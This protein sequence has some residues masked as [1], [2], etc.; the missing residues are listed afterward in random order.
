MNTWRLC[1]SLG[2]ARR[3]RGICC[4]KRGKRGSNKEQAESMTT[5]QK[6]KEIEDEVSWVISL[7]NSYQKTL[8]IDGKDPKK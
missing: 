3:V 5:V 4:Q 8:R 7:K 6:I 2:G 1:A